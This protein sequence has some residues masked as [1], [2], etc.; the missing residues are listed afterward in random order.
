MSDENQ[1]ILIVV[2]KLK[3]FI[4]ESAGMNTS[5]AVGPALSEVV[6]KVCLQAIENARQGG[7]KTV[8][9]RDVLTVAEK[10]VAPPAI[11]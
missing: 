6:R 1:E 2:S 10:L 9:D 3:K 11:G 8:M 4:K 5:D 7:R